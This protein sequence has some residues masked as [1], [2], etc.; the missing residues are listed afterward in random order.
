MKVKTAIVSAILLVSAACCFAEDD[1]WYKTHPAKNAA[2]YNFDPAAP[3]ED[4]VIAPPEMVMDFLRKYDADY[5]TPEEPYLPYALAPEEEKEVKEMLKKMPARYREII[6]PRLLGVYFVQNF[7]GSGLSEYVPGPDGVNYYIMVFNPKTLKDDAADWITWK[8]KS[9]FIIDD[10]AY[11][12]KIDIGSG[13]SGFYYVFYHEITHVLDYIQKMTPGEPQFES[14]AEY[15][16]LR[17]S[18]GEITGYEFMRDEW[19]E[20]KKPVKKYD[21]AGR[22]DIT[23]YGMNDGPKLKISEAAALYD[24]LRGTPFVSLYGSMSWMEDFA[25]F[26]AMYINCEELGR[27]WKLSIL[28]DGEV[29]YEMKDVLERENL[30]SRIEFAKELLSG[31]KGE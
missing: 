28:K 3:L 30:K 12:L 27:P 5:I 4:R 6:S 13:T 24:R 11:D 9:A 10:P 19:L 22:A 16:E 25:E 7:L 31:S 23:F 26:M 15:V 29:V 21:F 1:Q 8:E 17:K 14:A 18:G 20:Y 2:N